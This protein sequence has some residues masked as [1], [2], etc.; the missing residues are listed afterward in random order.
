MKATMVKTGMVVLLMC[1][2]FNADAQ[3]FK[4]WFRQKKTQR[5]YLLN[6]IAALHVY[7]GYLKRGYNIVKDGTDAISD[8]TGGEFGLH[9]NYFSRLK[10]VDPELLRSGKVESTIRLHSE[11]ERQRV[12][13]R[14]QINRSDY[15]ATDEKRYLGKLID[16]LAHDADNELEELLMV[17]HSDRL[18]LTDDERIKR[19]DG[20]YRRSQELYALHQNTLP[21]AI[22]L[23]ESRQREA[24]EIELLRKM[25]EVDR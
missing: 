1:A 24:S 5:E 10:E 20:I 14:R 4:E 6:Q 25:Y 3:T 9:R 11:M 18:E 16:G 12:E 7:S 22:G 19:I 21:M 2:C 15:I 23:M 17:I 13:T 8:F